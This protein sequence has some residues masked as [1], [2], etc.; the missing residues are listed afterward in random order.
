MLP[1]RVDG[2][3]LHPLVCVADDVVRIHRNLVLPLAG[4]R[5]EAQQPLD[6]RGLH[7]AVLGRPDDALAV[8]VDLVDAVL[9][10]GQHVVGE[11]A[12]PRIE[13]HQP[14][15]VAPVGQPH[16]A[17]LVEAH[18]L[19]HPAPDEV[20]G[21]PG[22]LRGV[23]A[24]AGRVL[25]QVVLDVH[26][27][28]EGLL[29]HRH[30]LLDANA[31]RRRAGSEVVD[32]IGEQGLAIRH[33]ETALRVAVGDDAVAVGQGRPVR[34]RLAEH[35][36]DGRLPRR[37][38]G[39][40]QRQE[41]PAVARHAGPLRDVAARPRRVQLVVGPLLRRG[42]HRRHLAAAAR[43][44]R[45]AVAG[46]GPQR[47]VQTGVVARVQHQALHTGLEPGRADGNLVGAG[48]ERHGA[49]LPGLRVHH[50]Q[51]APVHV[52]DVDPGGRE[53]R[54]GGDHPREGCRAVERRRGLGRRRP[55]AQRAGSAD[56]DQQGDRRR[57][58]GAPRCR[59]APHPARRC[60]LRPGCPHDGPPASIHQTR[61]RPEPPASACG[62]P[63]PRAAP[64]EARCARLA[65][66]A[67]SAAQTPG[68][69]LP[70]PAQL[71]HRRSY[72]P[73]HRLPGRYSGVAPIR[74]AR[75]DGR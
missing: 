53:R 57:D 45:R 14:V 43:R 29:V 17:V 41:V 13:L 49:K 72:S 50:V 4:L 69:R 22:E 9:R 18:V 63:S 39:R 42:A 74:P 37:A 58:R 6:L 24:L 60:R 75:S 48:E 47:Q 59:P 1:L 32:E 54:R 36:V 31:A 61:L 28:A 21:Q 38:A 33:R 23:H 10:V 3:R 20:A 5:V 68:H 25:R 7:A 2:Q 15:G 44:G 64:A 12:G 71:R 70:A 11:G 26:R 30:L 52:P 40:A 35:L 8:D 27:L 65:A 34:D 51:D 66:S 19:T 55:R 46:R 62:A 73:A 56:R 67:T 16:V